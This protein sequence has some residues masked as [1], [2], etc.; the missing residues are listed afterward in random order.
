MLRGLVRLPDAIQ[1]YTV[2]NGRI[3]A[4]D[5]LAR[6]PRIH[7]LQ[8]GHPPGDPSALIASPRMEE[9]LATLI[10]PTTSC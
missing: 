10:R 1:A 6:G 3:N 8:A 5:G 9:V 7:V 2:T 4:N